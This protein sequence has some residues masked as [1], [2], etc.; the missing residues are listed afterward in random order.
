MPKD[1]IYAIVNIAFFYL[2]LLVIL[3]V[4][5]GCVPRADMVD[6]L[7]RNTYPPVAHRIP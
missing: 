6:P 5:L 1:D 2:S 7:T 3:F 4:C